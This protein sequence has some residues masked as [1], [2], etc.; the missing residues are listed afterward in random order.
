MT[1]E[2]M[3]DHISRNGPQVLYRGIRKGLLLLCPV[4]GRKT[5]MIF[6][7]HYQ[8]V[9]GVYDE[10]CEFQWLVEDLEYANAR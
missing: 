4:D 9:I 5:E 8:T 1:A 10:N 7:D 2:D 6:R 3:W